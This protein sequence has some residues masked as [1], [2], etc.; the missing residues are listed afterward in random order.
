LNLLELGLGSE[1]SQKAPFYMVSQLTKPF[2]KLNLT[3]TTE[4]SK[5]YTKRISEI[6]QRRLGT[7]SEQDVKNA[8]KDSIDQ[9]IFD[10]K[11]ILKLGYNQQERAEIVELIELQ[12]GLR[13]LKSN[14]LEKRIR[15]LADIRYMIDRTFKLHKLEYLKRV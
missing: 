7:L 8:N 2:R 11:Q 6:I 5:A 3:L 10:L 1:K 14:Y 4:F 15:G 12:V 13:F 9:L